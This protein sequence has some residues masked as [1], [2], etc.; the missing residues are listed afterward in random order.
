MTTRDKNVSRPLA[1]RLESKEPRPLDRMKEPIVQDE[2]LSVRL[3]RSEEVA[4]AAVGLMML[5]MVERH[6]RTRLFER[7]IDGALERLVEDLEPAEFM[8][9]EVEAYEVL[10]W[11]VGDD[12]PVSSNPEIARREGDTV[13]Y[14]ADASPEL[15]LRE[16]L[17]QEFDVEIQYFTRKRAERNQRV[18]SPYA[19]AADKYVR[20]WCHSRRAQRV[21]RIDRISRC[22][23]VNG[24]AFR[25]K[26]KSDKAPEDDN[27]LS[28]LDDSVESDA[29]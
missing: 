8:R 13:H 6:G 7:A 1:E 4:A 24:K 16:A 25:S 2:R 20:A 28:L 17:F 3:D 11:L 5:N 12:E 10:D 29:S 27:Q 14:N 18:I 21:F 9:L 23:P 15:I 22:V 26:R 19:I